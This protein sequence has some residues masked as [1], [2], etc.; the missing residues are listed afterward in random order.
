MEWMRAAW[1]GW[2]NYKGHS[3]LSALLFLALVYLVMARRKQGGSLSRLA[4]YGGMTAV[5]CILPPTAALLMIYQTKFYEYEWLWSLVPVT[6]AGA[7]GAAVFAA[8]MLKK[9]DRLK[10]ICFNL[11]LITAVAVMVLM[12]G[13]MGNDTWEKSLQP[14]EKAV[15]ESVLAAVKEG[16]GEEEIC[17][18]A[19]KDI[20]KYARAVGSDYVSLFYG[21]NMWDESLNAYTYDTYSLETRR[22][23]LWMEK[24]AEWGVW[25]Q[26]PA[27]DDRQL[28]GV[29]QVATDGAEQLEY[30]I[31]AG[32]NVIVLR[33]NMNEAGKAELTAFA[34]ANQMEIRKTEGYFLL[35]KR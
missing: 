27:K 16:A 28:Y 24:A 5:L 19:P 20:M 34:E 35:K 31:R 12:C 2:Q 29:D 7:A 21:R 33:D 25:E 3:K 13:D 22:A 14:R 30:G 23:Y 18:W 4:V 9:W 6:A 11:V 17:L 32:V 15:A 8:D 26:E 10:N 1:T